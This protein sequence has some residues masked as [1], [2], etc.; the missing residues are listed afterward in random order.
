MDKLSSLFALHT[1]NAQNIGG[2]YFKF[3]NI[4]IRELLG[5]LYTEYKTFKIVL[6]SVLT[7]GSSSL[8]NNKQ[9]YIKLT[10]FDWIGVYEHRT[11]IKYEP[12]FFLHTNISSTSGTLNLLL[13]INGVMFSKPSGNTIDL[14][15]T[16]YDR[17]GVSSAYD[18]GTNQ[19]LFSIYGVDKEDE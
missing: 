15:I 18:M 4:N 16:F 13:G 11:V 6:N 12:T 7:S 17:G 10:G 19:F 9:F 14:T 1:S 3:S 2:N 5:D 8:T